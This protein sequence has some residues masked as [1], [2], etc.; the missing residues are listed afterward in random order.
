MLC[1]KV[2]AVF[3]ISFETHIHILCGK[4][5]EILKLNAHKVK[6]RLENFNIY[7]VIE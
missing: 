7:G 3:W 5:L 2:I 4:N 1:I 6:G